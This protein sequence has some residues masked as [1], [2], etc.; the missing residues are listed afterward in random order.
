MLA[1]APCQSLFCTSSLFLPLL[2]RYWIME[3]S[4]WN[5]RGRISIAFLLLPVS[6]QMRMASARSM[7]S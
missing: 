3:V 7:S 5:L 6:F 1:R 2:P 4:A